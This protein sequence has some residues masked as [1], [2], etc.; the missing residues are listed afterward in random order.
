M[1]VRLIRQGEKALVSKKLCSALTTY[2]LQAPSLWR[3]PLLHLALSLQHGDSVDAPPESAP[4]ARMVAAISTFDEPRIRA[5]LWFSEILAD[6]VSKISTRSQANA[7]YH[8]EMDIT[9]LHACELIRFALSQPE[10]EVR[11]DAL[12][13]F[14]SW[15][16]YVQPVWQNQNPAI[17]PLRSL[18]GP[19]SECL[20]DDVMFVEALDM[21]R[22]ILDSYM[23]FFRTQ[24]MEFLAQIIMERI[25]PKLDQ[26]IASND[27]SSA[28]PLVQFVVAYGC[29]NIQQV[30]EDPRNMLC[31]RIVIDTL[32]TI[33]RHEG[34][35]G[36]DDELSIHTVEFWNTYIEYIND[37]LYSGDVDAPEQPWIDEARKALTEAVELL[38]RKLWIPPTDIA[39]NWSD[40]ERESFKEFRLDSTDLMLSIFVFLGKDMLEILVQNAIESLGARL[41]EGVE[42]ALFCL[43]TLSDN[44]LE[45][46]NNETVIEPIFRSNLF[47]QISDFEQNIPTPTRRTAIDML[48]SYGQYI[49]RH[50]EFLG[51]TV[52]FLFASLEVPALAN[53]AAKSIDLLCSTCRRDLTSELPGF[54]SQY[55]RFL[56]SPTNESYPKQKVIGA[57]A[58]I[59][60][61]LTPES[62]KAEPLLAL[63]STIEKDVEE[64]K[65][66]A[67]AQNDEMAKSIGV[68]A[69][70]CLACVGKGLQVPDDVVTDLTGDG[71]QASD[72][73]EFWQSEV[74]QE[75][76][77][78]IISCLYVLQVIGNSSDAVDAACQVLRS[79][80]AETQPGP[81]VLPPM[82]T[83]NF[84][85][86][87][88]LATPQL[89][90]VLSTT[91]MLITS[92]SHNPSKLS[93]PDAKELYRAVTSFATQLGTSNTDPEVASS[94]IEIWT[95]MMPQFA[96]ILL[97]NLTESI[98]GFTLS[99]LEGSHTFPKRHACD[100]WAKISKPQSASISPEIQSRIDQVN[101]VY[102]PKVVLVLT[103]QIGGQAQRSDLDFLCEPLKAMSLHQGQLR[104]W[105]VQALE[106]PRFPAANVDGAAKGR[107]LSQF[108]AARGDGRF[109]KEVVRSFWAACKGTVTSYS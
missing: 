5:L 40:Q 48:G 66:C 33:I 99:A 104:N 44:V 46:G 85:Q 71:D 79:G 17:E 19:A 102:G 86:Q 41:W 26:Y 95:R 4:A 45:D 93:N 63:L 56:N 107:F 18:I 32:M 37:V 59:I 84:L 9:A 30:I 61:A 22:D 73:P 8:T 51:D 52:R 47:A 105:M 87:C 74:G 24:H 55:Q 83:V 36:D 38:F 13:A 80:F 68:S 91:C 35:P 49:E 42:A 39:S 103:F 34:I 20:R 21:F 94:C 11:A 31:S 6:E 10:R 1:Q 75:I 58:C 60:Q 43:N 7:V 64:T 25:Q 16:N 78:R 69:L 3:N 82:V 67:A 77:R 76:Q 2:F 90:A 62:A 72:Q 65:R 28:Q 97:E 70:E 100:F 50:P 23:T 108:M 101:A 106:D 109:I 88:S 54:L 12:L 89:E 53:T 57:I 14:Q 29:A 15:V 81:F 98:L 27:D 96:H 92:N